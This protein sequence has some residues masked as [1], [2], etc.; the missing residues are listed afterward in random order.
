MI[1]YRVVTGAKVGTERPPRPLSTA[2]GRGTPTQEVEMHDQP[3]PQPRRRLERTGTP[4]IYR[5]GRSYI[6][7]ARVPGRDGR[8]KQVAR[9]AKTLAEAR[10][11][12]SSIETD[13]R[14]GDYREPSR[15]GFSAYADRWLASYQ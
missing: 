4:G 14:R 12:K 7:M 15:E 9:T 1:P 13:V 2:R 8:R 10:A 11:I 6:V 5:R 3:T